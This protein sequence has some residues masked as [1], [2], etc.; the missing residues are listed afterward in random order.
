MNE[1]FKTDSKPSICFVSLDNFAA[2]A[3]D[4]KFGRIGGAEIQQ[5]L[6]G[7]NLV[8]LHCMFG[9][10]PHGIEY[11][12]SDVI[13]TL[14]TLRRYG[15][16]TANVIEADFFDQE[17]HNRFR[18]HFDVVFS[19]GFIEHFDPPDEVLNLHVNLLKPSG[20]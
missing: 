18:G 5:A 20:Y 4:Q 17:F 14:E 10:E 7:K 8:N 12:H 11:C 6:I 2:L 15:F 19:G 16:N 13:S 3:N 9:Y 1:C